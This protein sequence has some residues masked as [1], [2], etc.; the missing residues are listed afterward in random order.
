MST[1]SE[2]NLLDQSLRDVFRDYDLPPDD[3]PRVWEGVAERI[4]TLPAT[5]TGLSYRFLLPL[6]AVVGVGL[7]WLLPHPAA[8]PAAKPAAPAVHFVPAAV[9]TAASPAVATAALLP[10]AEAGELRPDHQLV[11]RPQ[12]ASHKRRAAATQRP[13]QA[14]AAPRAVLDS[15]S[16]AAVQA[17]ITPEVVAPADSAPAVPSSPAPVA[18]V[19]PGTP[20]ASVPAQQAAAGPAA[21]TPKPAGTNE[22][23]VYKKLSQRQPEGRRGIGR[24]FTRFFQGVRHWLS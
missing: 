6:T 12:A 5:S 23:I 18:S 10:A 17:A 3:H 2:D 13:N 8:V 22:K 4:A 1:Q 24:W 14:Q 16:T 11:A 9:A 20:L 21:K 15:A 7:G 19:H